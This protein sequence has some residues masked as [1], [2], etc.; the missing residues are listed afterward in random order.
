MAAITFEGMTLTGDHASRPAATAVG[1]GSLYACSDHDLIYQS[2][3]ATWATWATLGSSGSVATDAIWDAA[4]DLAV[5]SGANTASKLTAGSEGE[6]LTIA[7]GVPSWETAPGGGGGPAGHLP[8]QSVA[9]A[10][11]G[12]STTL[13]ANIAA[14]SSG[15]VLIYCVAGGGTTTV[16]SI[17]ST[18]TTWTLLHRSTGGSAP[19]VDIWKGVVAGGSS[20]TTVTVTYSS[21]TAERAGIISEWAGISGTLDQSAATTSPAATASYGRHYS[22]T[23]LPTDGD[24]LVVAAAT[25]TDGSTR[26]AWA[27]Q[28][29]A[30][31]AM[32][33][34]TDTVQAFMGAWYCFPGT[35]PVSLNAFGPTAGNFSSVIVSIT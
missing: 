14:A 21:S 13:V 2:D 31:D 18:N 1:A 9:V 5:G 35:V 4:G 22:P 16:S 19:H 15:N 29:V 17:A 12:G 33:V 23:I 30:F 11:A 32:I 8:I 28:M 24:A 25:T 7:S 10:N 3:G 27:T 26:Y 6:V 34:N 20:G